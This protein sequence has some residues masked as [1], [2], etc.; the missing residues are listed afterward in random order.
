M[1]GT[2]DS[3]TTEHV[4]VVVVG[5]GPTGVTAATLLAEYGVDTLVLDRWPQV[6]PQPRAVHL[7]DEVY[8]ILAR[9]GIAEEFA[10][11]SRA[12]QG[13]RL[14][15]R[16]LSV[17]AE[18]RRD[19]TLTRNG[20]PAASMF[21]QPQLE[22]LLR[23][24]LHRHP[25]ARFRGDTEVFELAAGDRPI[26]LR[27]RDRTTGD[28]SVITADFVLGCDGANSMVRTTIGAQMRNLKFDQRWLVV[29]IATDADLHQWE[30]VH[31]LCDDHR[32]GTYMRIGPTRYR[33]E[34][35]L[36]DH[37]SVDDYA[38]VAA[39]HPLIAPWTRDVDDADLQLIRVAEYT[40]RAQLADCWRRGNVFL[41]GDAAHLTPPF[42][43]QGMGSGLRDAMN[44]SWKIAGVWRGDL[45]RSA[46]DSYETERR[47]HARHMIW[48]A[49]NVGRAMTCGGRLGTAAR[50]L[51]LPWLHLVP[52]L[53]TKVTDSQTPPLRSSTLVRRTVRTGRVG[54]HLCRN[55]LLDNGSFLDDELG[56]G[57]A[58]I[59][60]VALS[61][62]QREIVETR[63]ASTVHA[64]A[65]SELARWLKR[66]Q[67]TAVVVRPDRA[68]MFASRDLD[69]VCRAVPRFLVDHQCA[70]PDAHIR[71]DTSPTA[72]RADI[73]DE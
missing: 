18:F 4:P 34:F 43:G 16:N 48:L 24:N 68:I 20:F 21:D 22:E 2:A 60:T 70:T 73:I 47:P 49:L 13:L 29:D 15:D 66:H 41:L 62:S 51:I 3:A 67:V 39:L 36:L 69:T 8:R 61:P 35:R 11:I 6:Y 27:M 40:F 57:F 46:L 32:A 7:D 30:G 63:G 25:R 26:R 44:L 55:V 12:A 42:I 45:S 54:G 9:L 33:W 37:E 28:E 23:T 52:G 31:Q 53:R 38:T 71:P 65:G 1:T 17:L 50:S 58:V 59:T 72:P 19:T 64:A 5:G 56:L 14:V 10:G